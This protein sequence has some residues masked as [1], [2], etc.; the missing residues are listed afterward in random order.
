M[1]SGN[2][3]VFTAAFLVLIA[4]YW[5][6]RPKDADPSNRKTA[7]ADRAV[8][9]AR[10]A[11]MPDELS[12]RK[13]EGDNPDST[14][15]ERNALL[16]MAATLARFTQPNITLKDLVDYLESNRQEP[17]TTR[18]SN[19]YTGEMAIVRTQ[20]PLPGTRYFHAQYFNGEDG[21]AF[22]QHMSFEYKP[23]PSAMADAVAAV[24]R[25]FSLGSPEAEHEGYVQWALKNGYIIWVK[26][27]AP[28]DLKDDPFNA[29]TAEDAGTIRV[30]I[31][32]EVH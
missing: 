22:V 31:E 5:M 30:A 7:V 16:E 9:V 4:S 17:L 1:R 10:S 26:K 3:L 21:E 18:N 8:S 19:P 6:R 32:A 13:T 14:E 15:R 27:M 20:S 12:S 11:K 29:Y 25:A 24:Q 23:G 2:K 28:E